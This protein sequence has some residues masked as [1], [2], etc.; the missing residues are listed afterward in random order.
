MQ[1]LFV[2]AGLAGS[3]AGLAPGVARAN[4][5]H[6]AYAYESA[7]LPAG[8]AELEAQTTLRAGRE[9]YYSELD[10][11]L[12]LEF[13][14][15]DRLQSSL[16][17]N[18]AGLTEADAANVRSS[19]F[20]YDGISSEWKLRLLDASADPVGLALYEEASLAPSS[21]ELETKLI[22]DK[23]VGDF[24]FAGNLI[25]AHGWDVQADHTDTDEE[26]GLEVSGGYFITDALMVGLELRNQ[27]L[28]P[29]GTLESSAFFAGPTLAYSMQGWFATVTVFPQLGAIKGNSVAG[30][31]DIRDLDGHEMIDVRAVL[32]FH[33]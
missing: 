31:S 15:T 23:R 1:K 3:L 28:M 13:A 21:Y 25:Y 16:Y 11:R 10:H 30:N 9:H 4:D 7:T 19:S 24:L 12:E 22:I 27:T 17:I 33:L 32:G 26:L 8:S 14:L 20:E 29:G 5:R 18:F 2:F 6:F